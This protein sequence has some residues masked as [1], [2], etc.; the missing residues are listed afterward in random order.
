MEDLKQLAASADNMEQL[1]EAVAEKTESAAQQ[2]DK[3]HE[4]LMQ[5]FTVTDKW[6]WSTNRNWK[7]VLHQ[8]QVF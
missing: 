6:D 8:A 2:L 4:Y 1:K 7:I 3:I 5:S